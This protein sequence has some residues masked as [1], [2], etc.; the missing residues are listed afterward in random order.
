MAM[1]KTL[2]AKIAE[3]FD[4]LKVLRGIFCEDLRPSP[5]KNL[6]LP[7]VTKVPD[8]RVLINTP[9]FRARS[10]RWQRWASYEELPGHACCGPILNIL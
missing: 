8:I 9:M 2:G 6:A 1:V 7:E 10:S 5:P 3:S 4:T